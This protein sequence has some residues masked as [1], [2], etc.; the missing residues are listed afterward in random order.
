MIKSKNNMLI[1][2]HHTIQLQ[3][4]RQMSPTDKKDTNK[5]I[6]RGIESA[7]HLPIEKP[8]YIVLLQV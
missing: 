7:N 2:F 3:N 6:S 5:W 8:L 4:Y 1:K